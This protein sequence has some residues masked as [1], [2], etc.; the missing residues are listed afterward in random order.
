MIDLSAVHDCIERSLNLFR[1]TYSPS[2]IGGGWYHRLEAEIPGPSA[3]AVGLN[4]FFLVGSSE[5][6]SDGLAFLRA[7]QVQ[8]DEDRRNGGWAVNTSF[9]QPVTEATGWVAR[10]LGLARLGFVPEAP[11][12]ER[13]YR[14]I[15]RNQNSDGGWGSLFGQPSR[16]WLTCMA[17]RALIQLNP[18]SPAIPRAAEW[19][20]EQQSPAAPAWGEGRTSPPTVTHTSFAL[21]TLSDVRAS[22]HDQRVTGIIERAYD[23][24]E[25][26]VDVSSIYDDA[27]RVENYNVTCE[28]DEGHVTWHT[29]VWHPG[30]PFTVSALLCHPRG[31]RPSVICSAV[32]TILDSQLDD[33]HWPNLDGAAGISVWAVWPFLQALSDVANSPY[34]TRHDRITWISGDALVLQHLGARDERVSTLLRSNRR[35]ELSQAVKRRWATIVLVVFVVL[36]LSALAGGLLAW[37]EFTLGLALPVTLFVIQE[38]QHGLRFQGK[39]RVRRQLS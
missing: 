10:F 22:L 8:S 39:R 37:Q 2:A 11:D 5:H 17:L 6:L 21:L 13:A 35:A 9:G 18:Q 4:S 7:R 24:L 32:Q 26:S 27:A 16:I 38:A 34:T 36:G 23:W 29:S 33:G 15:L 28:S 1:R 12:V 31:S 3:T 19:L 30:L 20:L 14:W 25:S